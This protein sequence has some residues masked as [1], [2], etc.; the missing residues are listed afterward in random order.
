[1]QCCEFEHAAGASIDEQVQLDV[2]IPSIPEK[3]QQS[4]MLLIFFFVFLS[5]CYLCAKSH[6]NNMNPAAPP[7]PWMF[8][9]M[10]SVK[11]WQYIITIVLFN[12][13]HVRTHAA[14]HAFWNTS[15]WQ[16]LAGNS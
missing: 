2:C 16:F 14:E 5:I 6:L 9:I 7:M 13:K 8:Q 15:H 3:I 10:P 11:H 1:M 4:A 12:E